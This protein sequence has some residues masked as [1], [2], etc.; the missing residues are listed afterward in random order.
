MEGPEGI[1]EVGQD[2]HLNP[3]QR[4]QDNPQEPDAALHIQ[5]NFQEQQARTQ[6]SPTIRATQSAPL[7]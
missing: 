1:D 3:T 6:T 5:E 2:T 4:Q 7:A